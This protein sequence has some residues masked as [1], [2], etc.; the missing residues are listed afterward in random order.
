MV[1]EYLLILVKKILGQAIKKNNWRNNEKATT[2]ET[3]ATK[4]GQHL[5]NKAEE[6]LLIC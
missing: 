1:K 4:T 6:K 2:V 3:A 5:G